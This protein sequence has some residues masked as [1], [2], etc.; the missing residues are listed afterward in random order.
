MDASSSPPFEYRFR[1]RIVGAEQIFRLTPGALEWESGSERRRIPY[2]DIAFVRL[3]YRPANMSLKRY[4]AEIWPREGAKLSM[5]SVSTQGPFNLENRGAIYSPFVVEFGK[6]VDAAQPGF[7]LEAGMPRWRWWPAAVF[8][9]ATLVALI[10]VAVQALLMHDRGL[11][12]VMLIFGAFFIWQAGMML[13]RNRPRMCEA[14]AVPADIL[15]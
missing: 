5:A 11:A 6:R 8:A 7:R 12:L 1:A 10:Y 14:R 3:S 2:R 15:P 13:L 9:G 4:L